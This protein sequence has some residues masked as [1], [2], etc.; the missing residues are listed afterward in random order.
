MD[1]QSQ[2]AR[3]ALSPSRL[4]TFGRMVFRPLLRRS[5][6]A[7]VLQVPGR[8]TG[9]PIEVTLALWQVDGTRYLTS[10]YGAADWVRNPRAAGHGKLRHKD[11]VEDFQGH[12]G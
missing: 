7:A 3:A 8:S 12:R 2:G 1:Q 4:L 5:G 6:V 10:Q 9:K 11:G